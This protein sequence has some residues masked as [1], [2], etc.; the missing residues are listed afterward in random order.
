[1]DPVAL[2]RT[3]P[4]DARIAMWH[5][6]DGWALRRFERR[7]PDPVRGRLLF[8]TGRGDVFEK[9]LEAL[10][11]WYRRGWSVDAFDWRGQG[12]SGR[13]AA[14]PHVGHCD[15]FGLWV[16]DLAAFWRRWSGSGQAP[17]VAVGHS[18]GAHLILRAAVEGVIDP[19]AIVLVAPMLGLR[20]P[21]GAAVGGRVARWM[22]GRGDAAR[23]AWRGN[24][25]PVTRTPRQMLLTH[26]RAR[27]DDEAWWY[28]R[29]PELRLGP[30]SWAWLAQAFASCAALLADPR[31]ATLST[32]V[33]MLVSDAD[34]LVDPR[35]AQ[36]VA[37]RLPRA[38]LV[39]YGPEAAHEILREADPVRVD[40]LSRIDAFLAECAA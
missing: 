22:A 34:G 24:E 40:A 33:L 15:D 4:T 26:D 30:P 18:M 19:D 13:M 27:Y 9:Y 7:G 28:E 11:H 29:H 23:P 17:R 25:R 32:P 12:G 3:I 6:P 20:S 39:R 14:D 1:M 10:E 31:L 37:D 8:Q 36:M 5:A 38:T 21:V 16:D 2:R 35:A